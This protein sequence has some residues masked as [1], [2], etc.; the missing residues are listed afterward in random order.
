[1]ARRTI[2]WNRPFAT[3]K[4]DSC[5]LSFLSVAKNLT[6]HGRSFCLGGASLISP[7]R[8]G[9]RPDAGRGIASCGT[10]RRGNRMR[11]YYIY[12]MTNH[13]GTL[14]TGVT[15]D[16]MRRVL[17]HRSR[18]TV[19]FTSKYNISRLLYYEVTNDI[20]GAIEREKQIKGW[21]RRKKL[22]LVRSKNPALR[23]LSRDLWPAAPL[24]RRQIKA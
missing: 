17:Q 19:G 9:R 20:R 4:G 8:L 18:E 6:L 11:D 12:I 13:R 24:L 23:D 2:C 14:N 21:L 10:D 1:M 22:E 15:N 5:V 3:L 7:Y 16:L